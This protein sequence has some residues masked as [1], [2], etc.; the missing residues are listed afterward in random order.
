[1]PLVFIDAPIVHSP[2]IHC[3]ALRTYFPAIFMSSPQIRHS[4]RPFSGT[5]PSPR[6]FLPPAEGT[7]GQGS[8]RAPQRNDG[9]FGVQRQTTKD[10][11]GGQVGQSPVTRGL[12]RSGLD[13]PL[14]SSRACLHTAFIAFSVPLVTRG[15]GGRCSGH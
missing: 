2:Q 10:G 14:C 4:T 7:G 13:P 11:G 3:V 1:M 6:P 8:A 9:L 15:E 12:Q 5:V